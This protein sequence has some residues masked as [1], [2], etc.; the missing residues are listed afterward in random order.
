MICFYYGLTAFA[1][2]WYFRKEAFDGFNSFLFKFLLPLLGGIGLVFVFIITL[3]D[4]YSPDYG[5]G[6][7]IGGVGLVFILGVGL[8]LFG[9]IIMAILRVKTPDFFKG[10]TLHRDT[11][12]LIPND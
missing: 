6:A 10:K 8:I 7:E 4:S 11:P 1:C 9:V 3:R 5:S 12:V 2:V